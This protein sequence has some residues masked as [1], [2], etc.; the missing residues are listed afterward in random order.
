MDHGVE[1]PE[2]RIAN[3]KV[4]KER[5]YL[6]P[7]IVEIMFSLRLTDDGAGINKEKV[8]KKAISK[9][10]VTRRTA[11]LILINKYMN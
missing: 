1:T 8:L 7:I 11:L 4:K 9:G 3:G 6:K 10:I 2:V 5:L